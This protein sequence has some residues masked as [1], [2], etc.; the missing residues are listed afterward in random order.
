MASIANMR[1]DR[2]ASRIHTPLQAF[3]AIVQQVN[4]HSKWKEMQILGLVSRS[5]FRSSESLA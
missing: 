1:A 2:T 4:L 5:E 3:C